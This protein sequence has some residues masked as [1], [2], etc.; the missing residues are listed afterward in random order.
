MNSWILFFKSRTIRKTWPMTSTPSISRRTPRRARWKSQM[1]TSSQLISFGTLVP[2][3]GGIRSARQPLTL[4]ISTSGHNQL[5]V[6]NTQN[7]ITLMPVQRK[8]HPKGKAKMRLKRHPFH[9]LTSSWLNAKLKKD[10]LLIKRKRT[11]TM[12][13]LS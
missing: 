4:Q 13:T 8:E 11:T 9:P 12:M 1:P 5:P 7:W 6:L 2:Q 10:L 3:I